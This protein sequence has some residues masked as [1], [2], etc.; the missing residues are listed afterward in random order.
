M[1]MEEARGTVGPRPT[2]QRRSI[3]RERSTAS[4]AHREV[5]TVRRQ[6]SAVGNQV[7]G[8]DL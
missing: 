3:R 6:W 4:N 1:L 2:S 7:C 5:G 8:G